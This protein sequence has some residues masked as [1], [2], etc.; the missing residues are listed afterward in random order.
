[1][2]ECLFSIYK[3]LSGRTDTDVIDCLGMYESTMD[4]KKGCNV[5]FLQ[6]S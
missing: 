3:Q 4:V 2:I 5:S 6:N 1:M